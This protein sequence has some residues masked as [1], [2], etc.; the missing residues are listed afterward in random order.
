MGEICLSSTLPSLVFKE[1]DKFFERPGSS[2]RPMGT[3]L[4]NGSPYGGGEPLYMMVWKESLCPL[5]HGTHNKPL[6]LR[7]AANPHIFA[8][9]AK[10][11]VGNLGV[12]KIFSNS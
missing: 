8:F 2:V 5:E 11:N 1:R 10:G 9:V 4:C 12:W 3:R 6:Q 7:L